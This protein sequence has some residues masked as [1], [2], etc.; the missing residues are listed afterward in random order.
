MKNTI[1]QATHHLMVLWPGT[2][3]RLCMCTIAT[4]F[5]KLIQLEKAAQKIIQTGGRK[6][7]IRYIKVDPEERF[8]AGNQLYFRMQN[9]NTKVAA[10]YL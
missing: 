4:M 7:F 3:I 10:Y 6:M 5:G 2:K 8:I 1:R 9:G